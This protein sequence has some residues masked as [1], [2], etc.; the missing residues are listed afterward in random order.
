MKFNYKD[1]F[2]N[3]SVVII[4]YLILFL[5]IM[6]EGI[7]SYKGS[8]YINILIYIIFAVS[9]SVTVGLLGLLNLGHAGFIAVGAYTGAYVSKLI[10]NLPLNEN[11]KFLFA[12]IVSGIVAGIIGILLSILTQKFSGDY[13]AII[14]LAFGEIIKYVIQNLPFLGGASGFKGIPNYTTFTITYILAVITIATIML[15]GYS[16]FGRSMVSIR[17]NVI[18]SENVGVN[19]NKIKMYGFFISAFFAGIGGSLFA[20]NLGVISPEK[21]SF[22]FSIEILVMVVFGGMG[23]ISGAILAASFITIANEFLRGIAEYRALIYSISL[24][25]IILYRPKGLLGTKEISLVEIIDK[26]KGIIK[27]GIIK[28]KKYGD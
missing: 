3:F 9:L 17:E 24:V 10:I 27:N 1:F 2:K 25:I 14:T 13:L 19:V 7:F 28:N 21:F 11:I 26:I 6:N 22:I 16:K 4:L 12:L 15:V 23:S 8:V 20:H 5:S 18:A